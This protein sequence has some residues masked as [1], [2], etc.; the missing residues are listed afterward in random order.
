MT[1]TARSQLPRDSHAVGTNRLQLGAVA[2]EYSVVALGSVSYLLPFDS[3]YSQC[4]VRSVRRLTVVV[5][6][7]LIYRC[8]GSL[9][10]CAQPLPS[11]GLVLVK[12]MLSPSPRRE[13]RLARPT[14]TN[15]SRSQ[16]LLL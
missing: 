10:S 14:S 2:E 16:L 5:F 7:W 12:S 3:L 9:R 15:S 6:K 8:S 1:S 11:A 13:V 4:S